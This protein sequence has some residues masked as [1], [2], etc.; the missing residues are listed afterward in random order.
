[1]EMIEKEQRHQEINPANPAPTAEKPSPALK[2]P[3]PSSPRSL[4][5]N[6]FAD[7][8]QSAKVVEGYSHSQLPHLMQ[9]E[10]KIQEV[11]S[12]LSTLSEHFGQWTNNYSEFAKSAHLK[13]ERIYQALQKLEAND[14]L[15]VTETSQKF[16]RINERFAER[17]SVDAKIQEMID[18]HN[19]VLKSFEMRMSQMQRQLAE[20]EATLISAQAALNETKMELSRL[21]RL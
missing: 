10:Q 16:S 21:K 1:M 18:R 19:S 12:Q 3:A 6:L 2:S 8:A 11:K 14:H 15:I 5:R 13:F 17:K 4:N 7:P 9:T 20:K